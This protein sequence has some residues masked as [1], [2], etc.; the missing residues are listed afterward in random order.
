MET[1][2]LSKAKKERVEQLK[3]MGLEY[4][5]NVF[6]PYRYYDTHNGRDIVIQD[7]ITISVIIKE[8]V[9]ESRRGAMIQGREQRSEEFRSLLNDGL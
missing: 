3:N 8:I 2:G 7:S 9:R 4:R 1:E 5:G 6:N